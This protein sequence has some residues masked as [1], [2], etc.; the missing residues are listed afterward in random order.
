MRNTR[1]GGA[2]D[3]N[4]QLLSSHGDTLREKPQADDD[5][6]HLGLNQTKTSWTKENL[7]QTKFA[8]CLWISKPIKNWLKSAPQ[9]VFG[10]LN[11][12]EPSYIDTC[13]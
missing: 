5:S 12:N 13:T 3:S 9:L 8:D 11:S 2:G 7:F 1:R 4:S 6:Q 10:Y